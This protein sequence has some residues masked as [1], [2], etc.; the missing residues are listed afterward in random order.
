VNTTLAKVL[1]KGL[2]TYVPGLYRPRWK[3]P[4]GTFL[5]RYC[6][7]VWL[8]HLIMA[9]KNGWAAIPATVAEL[10]PGASL[11]TGLAALLSGAQ[12][13]LALDVVPY[14]D[15]QRSMAVFDDLVDLFRRRAPIPDQQEFPQV[16]PELE[17]YDFPHAVLTE[18][19]LHRALDESRVQTIREALRNVGGAPA[20]GAMIAYVVPWHDAGVVRTETVDMV[21]SQAVLQYVEDLDLAYGAMRQWLRPGSLMSHQIGF[22]CHGAAAEWNGHWAYPDWLWTLIRGRRPSFITRLPYSAHERRLREFG[23]KVVGEIRG[24]KPSGIPRSRLAKPFRGLSDDDLA[25]SSAF[26]QAIKV[27]LA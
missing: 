14:V 19:R 24:R 10:G 6:Y 15:Q 18:E 12:A 25:T 9:W 4:A 17:T 11:G 13:Y 16:G 23:F 21:F 3:T 2:A 8:R 7:T 22:G 27:P 1:L 26:I 5:S 20:P